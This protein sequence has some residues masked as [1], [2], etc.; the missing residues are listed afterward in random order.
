MIP[1]KIKSWKLFSKLEKLTKINI[2]FVNALD[3]EPLSGLTNLETLEI[4]DLDS[5]DTDN[6]LLGL[7]MLSSIK[8]LS[9]S[10]NLTRNQNTS[11]LLDIKDLNSNQVFEDIEL[12]NFIFKN[13]EHIDR[14]KH[15]K[16][17]TLIQC[18]DFDR[19]LIPE[20]IEVIIK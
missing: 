2:S 10:A 11:I 17:L 5:K 12:Q 4:V 3:L 9:I 16:K 1:V 8:K 15:L 7:G 18:K 6:K 20:N 19:E 14:L 13:F